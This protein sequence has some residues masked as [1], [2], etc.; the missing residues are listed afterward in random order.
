MAMDYSV[1]LITITIFFILMSYLML[2]VYLFYNIN[3]VSL[4]KN[5]IIFAPSLLLSGF[6]MNIDLF[7]NAGK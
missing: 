6:A 5:F 4:I 2:I 3:M 7:W 1:V